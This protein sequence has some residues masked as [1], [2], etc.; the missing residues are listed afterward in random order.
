MSPITKQGSLTFCLKSSKIKLV[1]EK[2]FYDERELEKV[3]TT[4][5]YCGVGCQMDLNV[6]PNANEGK[7]KVVKITSPEPGTTT[8]D[9]NLCVKGRFAYDF[10]DHKDRLTSP[11]IIDIIGILHETSW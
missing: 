7:A 5:N 11:L 3:R 10:I 2:A 6:D 1:S 9:G 8:N 4:C